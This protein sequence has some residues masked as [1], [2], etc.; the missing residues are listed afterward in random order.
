M[1][2]EKLN[3]LAKYLDRLPVKEGVLEFDM[4]HWFHRLEGDDKP[5]KI[6]V[7][8]GVCV[9][10]GFCGTSACMLGHAALM[11]ENV[12]QGLMI[13][14]RNTIVLRAKNGTVKATDDDAG[15]KFFGLTQDQAAFLFFGAWDTPKEGAEAIRLLIKAGGKVKKARELAEKAELSGYRPEDR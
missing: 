10:E 15:A 1:N 5:E 9:E 12:E 4:G 2:V 6:V 11:P 13:G 14:G 7:R 3:K 8:N